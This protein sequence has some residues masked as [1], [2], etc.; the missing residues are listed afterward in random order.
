MKKDFDHT[1]SGLFGLGFVMSP[2]TVIG[3]LDRLSNA[4]VTLPDLNRQVEA[5]YQAGNELCYQYDAD[6]NPVLLP[7]DTDKTTIYAIGTGYYATNPNPGFPDEEIYACFKRNHDNNWTGVKFFTQYRLENRLNLYRFGYIVFRTFGDA[8][9]FINH[10]HSNLL[11]GEVWSFKEGSAEGYRRKTQYDILQSYL[12]HVFDKLVTEYADPTSKNYRKIVFSQ[13]KKYALFNTG[14]LDQYARDIYLVGEVYHMRPNHIFHLS[15]PKIAPGIVDLARQ[16]QFDPKSLQPFPGV[17]EFF[18]NLNEIIFDADVE[19]DLSPEKMEHIIGDGAK[20]G[21]FPEKYIELYR[22]GDFSSIAST[23]ETA[24]HNA[25]KIAKRNYKYVVPQYRSAKGGEPSKIQFLMPIY[26]DR[27]YGQKPDFALVL[28]EEKVGSSRFYIPETV[29]ELAW[30]YNNAR[31]ICK[32]EDTWL[33]P[34]MI[35]TAPHSLDED[36]DTL[37]D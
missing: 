20:R 13:D 5:S 24:I 23:L 6:G 18:H 15:G 4:P 19:I 32:P 33:N 30:A 22:K 9:R 16:Y 26:L 11:P 29:L 1:K 7:F 17:V 8:D 27:Q 12:Q 35:E 25:K 36:E 31:V 34:A 10:L 14:L 3:A 37:G 21:R 2:N 28:N